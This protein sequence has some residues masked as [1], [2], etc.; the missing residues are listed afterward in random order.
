M[1]QT[2][3]EL[4]DGQVLQLSLQALSTEGHYLATVAGREYEVHLSLSPE[5]A[6]LLRWGAQT[7]LLPVA[8]QGSRFYVG[9]GGHS[10]LLEK[11]SGRRSKRAGAP[12]GDLTASMNGQVTQILVKVGDVVEKGQTLLVLEAMKMEL[13]VKAPREGEVR[14]LLC[15]VG[16]AVER[17]QVLVELSGG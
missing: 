6:L 17:G 8:K 10:I 13:R 3:F 2:H 12:E 16:Q 7:Y 15:Q 4:P 9:L 14:Q 5:G 1:S 11:S